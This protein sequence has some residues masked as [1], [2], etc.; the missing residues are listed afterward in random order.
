M[1]A[2]L[3]LGDF[4]FVGFF[5][6]TFRGDCTHA[7][8]FENW[9]DISSGPKKCPKIQIIRNLRERVRETVFISLY[10]VLF[11]GTASLWV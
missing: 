11:Y 5:R 8:S 7:G 3:S 10:D 9:L 2:S 1:A 6:C 4:C